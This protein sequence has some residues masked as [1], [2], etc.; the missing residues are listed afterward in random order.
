L[1]CRK[2][3]GNKDLSK[4]LKENY[5]PSVSII[6]AAF[7]EERVIREKIVNLLASDYPKEKLEIII[8]SDG[9]KDNTVKIAK[10]YEDQGVKVLGFE[11]N[12]GRAHVHNES[13]KQARGEILFFSDSET[14][15]GT[16]FLKNAIAYFQD[17]AYGCGTGDYTFIP[18]GNIGQTEN[19]YWRMEKKL[20]MLEFQLGI[21]PFSSGGCFLIRKA[22]WTP[23]PEHLDIDNCLPHRVIQSG[24]KAFYAADCKAY[25]VTIEDGKT[26]YRK[27]VRSAL[28]GI[29]GLLSEIPSLFMSGKL[30]AVWVLISHRLLRYFTGFF[31]AFAF[32]SNICLLNYNQPIYKILMIGQILFY[33]LG[34]IGWL[35]EKEQLPKFFFAL[36]LQRIIYS[37][38]VANLA[39]CVA[40]YQS[41]T[42]KKIFGYKPVTHE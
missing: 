13:V 40:V 42:G 21:L 1:I 19:L 16:D 24:Y 17:E 35:E 27:R 28:K 26:H 5:T 11:Q 25:D 8:A 14:S 2:L 33:G 4:T 34:F 38:I 7:N 3:L 15:F 37:F 41:L 23:V 29:D 31:M 10:E 30:V 9:S 18:Q 36:K 32:V 22:L 39:L 6:V 12:R 20:W